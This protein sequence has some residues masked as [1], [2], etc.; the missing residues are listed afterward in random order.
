MTIRTSQPRD[1]LEQPLLA[2][3]ATANLDVRDVLITNAGDA[4][5][6]GTQRRLR[7]STILALLEPLDEHGVVRDGPQLLVV[8]AHDAGF[9]AAAAVGGRAR[10]RTC[11]QRQRA[12]TRASPRAAGR[13]TEASTRRPRRGRRGRLAERWK[14]IKLGRVRKLFASSERRHQVER[15]AVADD[16]EP[17]HGF[18]GA[19]RVHRPVHPMLRGT[20][21]ERVAEANY[22]R[23]DECK[24]IF[25][26]RATSRHDHSNLEA[27]S[28]RSAVEA[29]TVPLCARRA[30]PEPRREG[31]QRRAC[32]ASSKVFLQRSGRSGSAALPGCGRP[33][34]PSQNLRYILRDH[35]RRFTSEI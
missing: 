31:P 21:H 7:A 14:L 25:P 24:R 13:A 18:V 19:S 20:P 17:Q 28:S 32:A 5:Q 9:A 2:P 30:R 6:V 26:C 29:A 11:R 8:R 3:A 34:V 16:G 1:L 12:T 22:P 33:H 23:P 10:R 35:A 27:S 4:L 15:S